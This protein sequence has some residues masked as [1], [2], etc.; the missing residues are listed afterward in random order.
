MAVSSSYG[1][2]L[3]AIK[4]MIN[5]FQ[6]SY[7]KDMDIVS[8]P[9]PIGTEYTTMGWAVAPYGFRKLLNYIQKLYKPP[10]GIIVTENGLATDEPSPESAKA[11]TNT[12]RIPFF[13]AY[14]EEMRK[15]IVE[16][17]LVER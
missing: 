1:R 16:V 7:F 15:A 5:P 14:L 2:V 3:N 9:D 8:Y 17:R 4:P 6:P 11:D 13:K 12:T 10:G